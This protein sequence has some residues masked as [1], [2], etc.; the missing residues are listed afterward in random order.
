MLKKIPLKLATWNIRALLDT[1]DNNN[2]PHW[3]TALIA[4]EFWHYN[5]DIAALSETM[6]LDE[7]TLKEEG[8]VTP[9]VDK[10]SL[11]WD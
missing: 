3:R 8:E 10:I 1:G 6:F 4:A 9:Q 11:V 2:R 7:G 5:I